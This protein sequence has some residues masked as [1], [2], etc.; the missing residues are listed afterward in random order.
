MQLNSDKYGS[1]GHFHFPLYYI[2]P[3]A[4]RCNGSSC[5][6]LILWVLQYKKDITS[7]QVF[8]WVKHAVLMRKGVGFAI[9]SILCDFI[10]K[11]MFIILCF[12]MLMM[13]IEE[14]PVF[15]ELMT[16]F[17]IKEMCNSQDVVI[18]KT[19]LAFKILKTVC[20]KWFISLEWNFALS[21]SHCTECPSSYS[22][23]HKQGIRPQVTIIIIVA[24]GFLLLSSAQVIMLLAI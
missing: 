3:H 5:L 7:K 6:H 17:C 24:L 21:L 8:F 13:H 12:R 14:T 11:I 15:V 22:E 20:M 2:W 18:T 16:T 1:T 10:H 9:C 4:T 19:Q 23:L